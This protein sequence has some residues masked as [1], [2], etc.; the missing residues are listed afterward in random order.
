MSATQQWTVG[1]DDGDLVLTT[2]KTGPAARTGH[3]LTIGFTDW[4]GTVTVDDTPAPQ[5]VSV[6]IVLDSLEVRSGEGG[7][8]PMTGAERAMAR[9]NALKSL[10]ASKFPE[11]TFTASTITPTAGGYR[12]DGELTVAGTTVPH[13]VEVQVADSGAGWDLR[14]DTTVSHKAVGLKPYTLAMGALKVAD[15]VGVQFHAALAK[16]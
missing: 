2:D 4:T 10:K 5:E 9:S 8:T 1:P 16:P 11:I 13:I 14:A 12:L 6:R 15:E 7:L 3:R